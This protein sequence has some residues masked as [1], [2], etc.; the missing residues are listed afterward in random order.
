[1]EHNA[2]DQDYS[3]GGPEHSA[4]GPEHSGADQQVA[5]QSAVRDEA[6]PDAARLRTLL[7]DV[8]GHRTYRPGQEPVI[9][10]VAAG[11][12]ALVVMPTG[13]GKSL[14]FQLPALYR[15]G[16]AVVVSPL[17]ALMKDQ[18]DAL[19]TLGVATTLIN[20]SITP[21][22]RETRL[23]QV[24]DGEVRILYVAPERFR[25][26]GFARRLG[27]A[28]V[29]LFVIDE[30][31]CLSQ[32]GH[33]FRPDYLRLGQVRAEL[34]YPPTIAATATATPLVRQDILDTLELREPGV[35][36]TGFD[37]PNLH[38]SVVAARS[39]NHKQDLLLSELRRV[40]RPALVYCATRRSVKA[41]TEA[42]R[43]S[44]ERCAGYHAGLD[45]D[46]RSRIQDLFMQ[47]GLPVV[48]ATNAFG[49]GIDK[50]NIRC[51]IHY[52]IPRTI[53]AYYQEIGRAG[54]DG[55]PAEII[56]L[57]KR[58]DRSIQEFFIDNSHPPEEVVRGTWSALDDAATNPV[59]RSHQ[60]IA[61]ALGKGMT[62]RMVSASMVVLEREGWLSRLPRR[63]GLTEV[64]F[65][66]PAGEGPPAPTRAGLP[67]E[68]WEELCAL[69]TRGG[70]PI[71]AYSFSVPPPRSTDEFWDSVGAGEKAPLGDN[72]HASQLSIAATLPRHIPL[73]LPTLA[74]TLDVDRARLSGAMRRLED[75][76]LISWTQAERCS[77]ARLLRADQTFDL[78]FEPLRAR[79][80]REYDKLDSMIA[81]ADQEQCRRRTIL[82][83]FGESVDWESCGSCDV[84]KRGPGT[85]EVARA[86]QADEELVV[87]KAL[88]CVARMGNGHTAAMVGRVLAGSE[89]KNIT[90]RGFHRLS[91]F[92]LLSHLT[93]DE[94]A[95]LLSALVRAG[96]LVETEV[97][98]T[99]RGYERRYRVLNL[100]DLGKAV[101]QQQSEGFEM[102]FP[103]LGPT[104]RRDT[105]SRSGQSASDSEPLVGTERSLFEKLREVRAALADIDKRPAYTMGSNALL[106]DIARAR[107]SDRSSLL[108][109]KGM[110]ERMFEKV[111][112]PYLDVVEAFADEP[113][114]VP[115]V[116][117]N[118]A[119]PAIPLSRRR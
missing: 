79:R 70:H 75:L 62:D 10:H 5:H 83:Y 100:A 29:G 3:A 78:D 110:G 105:T 104:A 59:F 56:L 74:A 50:D 88:S 96:C 82:T 73:H 27:Q 17:I 102:V 111:G 53:E 87:R 113:T 112:Q 68:L 35:F 89:A 58:G 22:E 54:R 63:E 93:Q 108:A 80:R 39:K 101:M 115:T 69:R 48:A 71:E 51:V 117:D 9:N 103:A 38:L 76:S 116:H 1:M 7:R 92:G 99:I 20:S 24:I 6:P 2:N 114:Q 23:R 15:E 90:Q 72:P 16:V 25:G 41:V 33:D 19:T 97:T 18:V 84:C 119:D 57:Y 43:K 11:R 21:D 47:G 8:F 4:G 65:L 91:T 26:G 49:M 98:R 109:L 107:P 31:H 30:A 13:A 55:K 36:V 86:L 118:P 32:W 45:S 42:L 34:G 85:V 81:F 77:G 37:R 61:D 52:D 106:R 94:T 64:R 66:H 14:C 95:Q 46:E 28:K 40:G 67:R 44:G 12:D 60:A